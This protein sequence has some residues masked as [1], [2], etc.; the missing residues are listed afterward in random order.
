MAD[1]CDRAAEA[2]EIFHRAAMSG[3]LRAVPVGEPGVCRQCDE[4][5]PRLVNG[6]CAPCR[7]GRVNPKALM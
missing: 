4:D 3:A 6:R 7:D 5:M 2:S 1:E